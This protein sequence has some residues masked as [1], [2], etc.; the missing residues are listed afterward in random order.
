M[1]INAALNSRTGLPVLRQHFMCVPRLALPNDHGS[2]RSDRNFEIWIF[3]VKGSVYYPVY[4]PITRLKLGPD[5]RECEISALDR[6]G[7]RSQPQEQ[8]QRNQDSTR[9]RTKNSIP[10]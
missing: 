4:D 3:M 2:G 5:Y 9:H 7:A 6:K 8:H 1:F 10:R